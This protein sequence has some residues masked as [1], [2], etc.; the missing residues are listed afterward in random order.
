MTLSNLRILEKFRSHRNI[1][2]GEIGS[3]ILSGPKVLRFL[4]S[5]REVKFANSQVRP[6]RHPVHFLTGPIGPHDP[7]HAASRHH[8]EVLVEHQV[9]VLGEEEE[10]EGGAVLEE[11]VGAGELGGRGGEDLWH[12]LLLLFFLPLLK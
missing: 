10:G 8:R 4:Q 9:E 7:I 12:V 3:D 2:D 6:C 1:N 5:S 11:G